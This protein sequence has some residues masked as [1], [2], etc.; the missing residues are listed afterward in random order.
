MELWNSVSLDFVFG[1]PRDNSGNNGVVTL[2]D[3][4]S[5][6][7]VMSAVSKSIT[8]SET[9]RLFFDLVVCRHGMVSDQDPRLTSHFWRALFALRGTKLNMSSADH[10]ESDCQS[11]RS[12]R[13]LEDILRSYAQSR[14]RT[15]SSMFPHVSFAYNTSV[16]ASTG[17]SPYYADQ[18]RQPRTPTSLG[19]PRLSGGNWVTSDDILLRTVASV[20]HFLS[21]R[22][23]VIQQIRDD[24]ASA[25]A[26]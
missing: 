10:P 5:K 21:L 25:Q 18:L 16:H 26:R 1:L 6:G 24:I 22:D 11:E 15:W 2:T 14:P 17:V 8:A 3:R 9:A 23:S 4:C 12:N 13:I 7:I 20:R 19:M